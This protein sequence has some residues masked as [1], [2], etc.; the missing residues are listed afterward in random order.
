MPT[1]TSNHAALALR[2]GEPAVR[3]FL[4]FFW[5]SFRF[6]TTNRTQAYHLV[7][8]RQGRRVD[9]RDPTSAC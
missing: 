3:A 5:A 8:G 7:A 9:V 6:L 4:L 2:F 1:P